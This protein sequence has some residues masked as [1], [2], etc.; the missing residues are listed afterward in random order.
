[1]TW[2]HTSPAIAPL[3]ALL[4]AACSSAHGAEPLCADDAPDVVR[5]ESWTRESHCKGVAADYDYLFDETVVRRLDIRMDAATHD[6]MTEDLGTVLGSSSGGGPGRPG[7]SSGTGGDPSWFAVDIDYDGM[8]WTDVGMRYKGNSSLRSAWQSGTR[9]LS[10]RLHFD[11][12]ADADPTLADQRFWGFKKMTFSNAYQDSSLIRDRVAA[13]LFR[14]AGVPAARGTFVRVYAD[15]G[16]GPVYFGLYTM[17]EDPSDDMLTAQFGDDSGNL[18][19]PEG[20]SV[21]PGGGGGG[22]ASFVESEMI[23]KTN[24]ADAD[25]SD[26]QAFIA[27]LNDTSTSGDAWRANLEATIDVDGFLDVLALNQAMEN[28]DSYGWMFHNFYLYGDPAQGG[29]LVWFPWDLNESLMDRSFGG[30]GGMGSSAGSVMLDEVGAE[31]PMIRRVLDDPTYRA[32]YEAKLAALLTG[33]FEVSAVEARMQAYHDL[34][35]PY[36]VGP[37]SE[38]AAPYTFLSGPEAFEQSL[39][40]GQYALFPHV[41]SRHEAVRTA[42]GR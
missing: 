2:T 23:K 15:W 40:A 8:T 5:P 20:M 22:L 11:K 41:E 42:L 14:E 21:G 6:A 3:L 12:F 28:W 25:Y 4:L 9:K 35:A 29:R 18:Y 33:A 10:F 7:G 19:K 30:P 27:A 36:V 32:S 17:I 13:D 31:W 37:E 24:E 34:I 39:S 26:V 1:M 16:E 38:E